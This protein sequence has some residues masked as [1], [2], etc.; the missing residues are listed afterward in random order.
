ML[1]AV[2]LALATNMAGWAAGRGWI[3]PGQGWLGGAA[4]G[5]V[6]VGLTLIGIWTLQHGVHIS[7]FCWLAG[8]PHLLLSA[9]HLPQNLAAPPVVLRRATVLFAVLLAPVLLVG[10]L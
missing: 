8:L 4:G 5:A 7:W 3:A 6:L 10:L 2:N 9:R 1:G